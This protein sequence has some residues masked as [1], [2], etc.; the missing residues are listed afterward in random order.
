M[1]FKDIINSV[2]NVFSQDAYLNL[3]IN[4]MITSKAD[5]YTEHD[6]KIYVK[7][8]SGV[9]ENKLLLDYCLSKLIKGQ[10]VK[11]F[12]KN[13]LRVAT[14]MISFMN[15]PNHYV[16]NEIVKV[17]K[18][19]DFRASSFVNAILR[20]Y[21]NENIYNES[22]DEI[23]KL[24]KLERLSILYSIDLELVKLLDSQYD[25][26]ESILKPSM[27]KYNTYRINT[28]KTSVEEVLEILN[29]E[30][31]IYENDGIVLKT[32][33]SLINHELFTLG[34]IIPQD[35]SSIKV[36]LV[37][38]PDS[39]S[40][41]LDACSAPGAKSMHMSAIMN[42]TGI[43]YSCD[44]H[45]HKI[46]LIESNAKKLGVTNVKTMLVDSSCVTFDEEFDTVL[47]DVPCSG[48]GVINHKSDLKYKMT[49]EKI[50][51]INALQKQILNNLSKYVKVNGHLVYSTC[52]INKDEN[53]RL[54]K[55]FLENHQEFKMLEEHI[56]VQ[57]YQADND[58]FY[59]AKLER[60]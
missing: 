24:E 28:L 29:K 26:L 17:V 14:Y 21:I 37:A 47:L 55:E 10:R 48:L 18:K 20:R 56:I 53:E 33:A 60:I 51:N 3:T 15:T 7:V 31:Y 42:N 8:T 59:I 23:N 54:I 43:I 44:V 40:R 45:E 13:A 5:E 38:S 34:K 6:K 11:P 16:V 49:L 52:T 9:V 2:Y 12:I 58:G 25:E 46:K 57:N 36:G 30:E 41:V 50:K 32:K 27:D 39:N 22:L 4:N 1:L 35:A 19:E